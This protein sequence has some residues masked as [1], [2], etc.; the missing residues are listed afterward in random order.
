MPRSRATLVL[1]LALAP[2]LLCAAAVAQQPAP[3][4]K[5]AEKPADAPKADDGTDPKVA[6]ETKHYNVEA[7][8]PA[9]DGYDPVA[10]FPE[11]G[12]AA[13]KGE[14]AHAYTYRG[15]LYHFA[16]A[17]NLETFKKNPRKYE[18]QHG[19]WCAYAMGKSGE[20]VEIDPKSFRVKEGRL[21]LFYKDFFTDTR[22]KWVKDEGQLLPKADASWKKISGEE[23][24]NGDAKAEKP[25]E[26]K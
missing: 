1:A 19:G 3:A 4:D 12:G 6:R 7:G 17:A 22:E 23:V 16:S 14:K 26:K 9:I 25:A 15:V 21:F 8:K 18:P 24:R 2:A 5:P 10:Y 20:K 13:K 11:G